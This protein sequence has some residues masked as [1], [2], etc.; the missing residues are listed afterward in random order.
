[1]NRFLNANTSLRLPRPNARSLVLVASALF[2][3]LVLIVWAGTVGGRLREPT[4]GV[5]G[6]GLTSVLPTTDGFA[7][8]VV[9]G[10]KP[11]S[12]PRNGAL[13]ALELA[14]KDASGAQTVA[15]SAPGASAGSVDLPSLDGVRPV[16]RTGSVDITVKSVADA[17]DQV[18]L[19]AAQ[20]GGLVANSSFT[21]ASKQGFAQL[22]LRVP[23]DRFGDVVT[24]LRDMAVEVQSISTGSQD[25][26]DQ[27]TDLDATL[28][29]L[30][31]VETRYILLLDQ[32]RNIAEILQVQ[33]RVN[34]VRLQI[35]RTEARRQ[36]IN[37][38]VE[39]AT[40]TVTLRPVGAVLHAPQPA[41]ALE[42]V[43]EAWAASLETLQTVATTV[44]VALVYTWWMVLL[45]VVGVLALRRFGRTT[46]AAPSAVA[47]PTT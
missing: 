40:L 11:A 28:R 20:S 44:L 24:R 22:T 12:E 45:A 43:R 47:P 36:L 19:L 39:M 1:M 5:N 46:H 14:A 29:N 17:F 7:G 37:G 10:T 34:Q 23:G 15:S 38:Q 25:V 8:G 18:R 4:N 31:A 27:L 42:R 30:R 3:G 9:P 21:G 13:G 32:A 2:V 26:A 6:G 33:D 35:D 41:S 16:I